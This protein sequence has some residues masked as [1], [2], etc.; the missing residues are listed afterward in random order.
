MSICNLETLDQWNSYFN[1]KGDGVA[2]VKFTASWCG[3]CQT[4]S[5]HYAKLSENST[6]NCFEVDVDNTEFKVLLVKYVINVMPT[7]VKVDSCG[8]IVGKM[9]GG[10]ENHL[11]EFFK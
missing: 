11:T 1:S 8:N 9:L 7:F 4:V 2:I 6:L 3:P 5:P 10:N